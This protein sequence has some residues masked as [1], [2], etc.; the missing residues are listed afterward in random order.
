MR[1]ASLDIDAVEP[2]PGAVGVAREVQQRARIQEDRMADA[3]VVMRDAFGGS[4]GWPDTPDVH[5]IGHRAL[6]EVDERLIGGPDEESERASP[7]VA[8]KISRASDGCRNR[9]RTSDRQ[10]PGVW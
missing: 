6:D 2:R 4:P 3:R 5:G 7:E 1:H 8:E 10:D 9:A